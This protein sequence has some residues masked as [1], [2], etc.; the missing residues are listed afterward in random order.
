MITKM[1]L[2]SR[3][4]NR[5]GDAMRTVA[6]NPWIAIAVGLLFLEVP[7]SAQEFD[8]V[9]RNGRVMDP[10]SGLDAVRD[11]GITAG[12]I[13]AVSPSALA[14]KETIDARGLVVAPGF[15]D[16]HQ[17]AWDEESI[18]LKARDGVTSI[19]E[20]EVGT[21]DVDG[22]YREREMFLLNHGVSIGHIQ[23]R[24]DVMGDP[25]AFLPASNARAV[26]DTA[27]DKQIEAMVEKMKRGLDAGAVA[28]GFGIAY[29]PAATNDEILAMFKVAAQ[30]QAVCHVHLRGRD[31]TG[32][33]TS[34]AIDAARLAA[35]AG[36][37]LCLVHLQ[38]S[39]RDNMPELLRLVEGLQAGGQDVSAEVYP[40]TAGMTEIKSY[41]FRDG[42]QQRLGINY[43]DFQ[44]G[45]NGERL[46]AQ[47]FQ[48]Y[49]EQGGLV[50]IHNN[51][52]SAVSLAVNHPKMMIASD[53]LVGH[54][55]N[56]G[57][58]ARVLGYY[59]RDQKGLNLMSAIQKMTL[60]PAQRLERRVPQ[61][62]R[63]G[64]VQVGC[65][66]DLT[67]FDPETVNARANYEKP[68]LASAGIPWV[69]V[70]GIPVVRNG[71]LAKTQIPGRPIR[72]KRTGE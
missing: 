47:S 71:E 39:G 51:S 41:M 46:N 49:R 40:W 28:I 10:Q 16:L 50:I 37:S 57:T 45:A 1:S 34:S 62:R 55:R 8:L 69:L 42:F 38:A 24:M 4:L 44:W 21:A 17:H 36:A 72:A 58:F 48:R 63:K 22:W 14:G 26:T 66:A 65:D 64:R 13:Q 29:T 31:Q 25:P 56:A 67:I 30:R 59:V 7:A 33:R 53:G 68:Y 9:I 54:P 60:M 23:V 5:T 11:V 3:P 19:L 43:E 27:T 20:L 6:R 18:R 2:H 61:M 70:H 32:G 12:V 15:I 35:S 52:E